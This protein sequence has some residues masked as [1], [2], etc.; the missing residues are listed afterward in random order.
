M[1]LMNTSEFTEFIGEFSKMLLSEDD[2][3]ELMDEF[4]EMSDFGNWYGKENDWLRF[5]DAVIKLE[6]K[7]IIENVLAI[8]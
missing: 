8:G 2:L 3:I 5:A 6:K 4:L 7:R 1:M